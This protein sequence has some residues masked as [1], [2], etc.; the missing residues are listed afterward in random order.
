ME[1]PNP[2]TTEHFSKDVAQHGFF[3]REGGVSQGIYAGLNTGLG[4]NDER[5]CVLEN[6]G[7][8][9]NHMGVEARTLLSP[10][11]IHSSDVVGS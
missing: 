10:Y 2:V 7:R 11:Q 9:A 8:V 4:S 1:N 5:T 6:R 3:T